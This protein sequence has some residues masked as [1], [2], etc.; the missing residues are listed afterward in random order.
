MSKPELCVAFACDTEDNLPNYVPGWTNLGS[1]YEKN[2]A[3]LNW[4]WT[5]YWSDLS[6]CFRSHNAPVTW[7]IR[8]DNGPVYDKMLTRYKEKM[9]EL[10]SFGDEIGI[11][12]H[13]WSWN[14]DLSKWV[15]TVNPVEEAKIV[16][17]SLKVFRVT[18]GFN[19]LSSSMGWH[20]MSNAIMGTLNANGV[21]VDASALPKTSSPGKFAERDNI[22]DWSRAS[23]NPYNPSS[24]DYQSVGD[25]KILEAP[26]SSLPSN[27][28]YRTSI[29]SKIVTKLSSKKSLLNLLPVARKLNLTPHNNFYITPWWSSSVYSKILKAYCSKAQQ[30]G[31]AFLIGTFHPSD[32]I[33]PKSG[34]KNLIFEEYITQVLDNILKLEGVS[35]KFMKLS[36]IAQKFNDTSNLKSSVG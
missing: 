14:A 34:V 31:T 22:F 9:H 32:I 28:S 8:V 2:P 27:N 12:I 19:P 33:D 25:M 30:E 6:R 1:N 16:V 23:I 26:I 15:Q 18:L 17:A 11:H 20:A 5:K 10:I 21:V 35:I 7:L 24:L 13:T 29:L 36:E 3:I 4:D